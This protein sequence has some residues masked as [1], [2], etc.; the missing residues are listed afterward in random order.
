MEPQNGPF[1]TPTTVRKTLCFKGT[2]SN[3]DAKDAIKLW[4]KRQEA[5]WFHYLACARHHV[6]HL[7]CRPRDHRFLGPSMVLR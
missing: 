2:M 6:D 7:L 1:D 4:E 3:R 5:K